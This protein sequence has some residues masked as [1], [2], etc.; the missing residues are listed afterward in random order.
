MEN[1]NNHSLDA[2]NSRVCMR[3]DEYED[4]NIES[5]GQTNSKVSHKHGTKEWLDYI[6]MF[7]KLIS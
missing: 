5:Q 2:I 7:Y 6:G 3:A 1:C 4:A